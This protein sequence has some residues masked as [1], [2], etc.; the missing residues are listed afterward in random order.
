MRPAKAACRS[1]LTQQDSHQF[2]FDIVVA[3]AIVV[4]VVVG[5]GGGGVA[6]A[7]A[8]VAVAVAVAVIGILGKVDQIVISF[9]EQIGLPAR[10]NF[11]YN[12]CPYRILPNLWQKTKQQPE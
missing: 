1:V 4:V 10:I 3:V 12:L 9:Q 2:C 8:A 5:G 6:A 7:A 11:K